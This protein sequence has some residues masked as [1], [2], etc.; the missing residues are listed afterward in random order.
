MKILN[1][2]LTFCILNYCFADISDECSTQFEQALKSTCT[3]INTNCKF[4][5]F[6]Q[7]CITIGSCGSGS[8][9]AG[10]CSSIIPSSYNE[11]KCQY[12]A[13]NG[14]E[15]V[16][17]E[18]KDYNKLTDGNIITGDTCSSLSPGSAT[19]GRCALDNNDDCNIHYNDC[20]NSR[21]SDYDKC[22]KNIPSDLARE[23]TWVTGSSTCQSVKRK[24][25]HYLKEL[26]TSQNYCGGLD[27]IDS[28]KKCIYLNNACS[29]SYP[30][31]REYGT[32][33]STCDQKMPL[34]SDRNAYDFSRKCQFNINNNECEEVPRKCRD[35][36]SLY[37]DNKDRCLNTLKPEDSNK[38]CI[39]DEESD[40][41]YEWYTSC[42]VYNDN[43]IEKN[44]NDCERI[45]LSDVNKRCV[46]IMEEDKCIEENI[47]KD[48]KE[49]KGSDKK[50]CESII[51]P[52]T[53][54]H[55][56][57]EKDLTCNERTF[58]CSE[59]QNVFDCLIYAKPSDNNKKC[60]YYNECYE[61]YKGCEDLEFK[62]SSQCSRLDIINGQTCYYGEEKC[63]SKQ[64]K[65]TEALTEEEC[66][67]IQTSGV[68]DPDK[69]ICYY[70]IDYTWSSSSKRCFENY[71]YCSDYR[72]TDDDICKSIL[73]YDES[74]NNIDYAYKCEI[75]DN[76]V[77][78]EKVPKEC[79]DASSNK[80]L[81]DLISPVINDNRVKYC[82]YYGGQCVEHYKTCNDVNEEENVANIQSKC[83][84]NIPKEYLN[85]QCE[86]NNG[87]CED[88]KKCDA[89][90]RRDYRNLC[91]N[92]SPN[93][94]YDSSS[95][96]CTKDV[97]TCGKIKFYADSSS[98]EAICKAT[99]ATNANKIC[100]LKDDKSG[101][102]EVWKE[103]FPIT[104]ANAV[105]SSEM[106]IQKIG[107]ILVLVSLLF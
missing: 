16:K 40:D 67:M 38:H 39:Y 100:V 41:C 33:R 57:L 98:N 8:G 5:D 50:V 79:T 81:C 105:S 93:C 77:G 44:R 92:I 76:E 34:N 30:T 74:G 69:K 19:G 13:T 51:S 49:Y 35:Y 43:E 58:H 87:K 90:N 82:A 99:N 102:E 96:T 42:Q 32:D 61:T 22:T 104:K 28:A 71:K 12:S 64:K 10:T 18:C 2:I 70:G 7:R 65:C 73:P 97:K 47:Y 66:E 23:C 26:A 3:N 48:C 62:G 14:C 80:I 17:K 25:D 95:K 63:K 45:I 89:F 11:K 75:K 27:L 46:F 68:S 85:T 56:F 107:L 94:K 21:L 60:A 101:C 52:K 29:E 86:F 6:D 103:D 91:I 1:L 36:N 84:S 59:A 55:C 106:P 78:C 15:E 9:N 37:G 4:S 88:K 54:L 20:T 24:C 72:G 31:C 53:N 83:S